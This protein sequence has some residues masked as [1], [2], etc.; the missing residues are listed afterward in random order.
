MSYLLAAHVISSSSACHSNVGKW[1]GGNLCDAKYR[2]RIYGQRDKKN[3]I[4]RLLKP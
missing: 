3:I 4:Q 2:K 1:V